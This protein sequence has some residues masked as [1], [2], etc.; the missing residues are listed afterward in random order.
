MNNTKLNTTAQSG[1]FIVVLAQFRWLP[2]GQTNLYWIDVQSNRIYF[3]LK[4]KGDGK[5]TL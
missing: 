1:V 2:N 4:R 3:L 5:T